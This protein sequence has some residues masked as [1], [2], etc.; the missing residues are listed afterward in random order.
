MFDGHAGNRASTYTAEHL[1]LNIK[2]HIP[3]GPLLSHPSFSSVWVHNNIALSHCAAFRRQERNGF[4]P[5]D[6][7]RRNRATCRI[8]NQ[9]SVSPIYY[10][11]LHGTSNVW[12]YDGSMQHIARKRNSMQLCCIIPIH[13]FEVA[14]NF[15]S[16][17]KLALFI[18][19]VGKCTYTHVQAACRILTE[20]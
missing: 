13:T 14:C 18:K 15:F 10:I 7:A 11:L 17:T 1:H 4:C 12:L 2:T 6:A 20:R 3:K 9:A 8:V 5:R 16:R 19:A